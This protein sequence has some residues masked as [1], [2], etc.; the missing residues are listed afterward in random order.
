M[1]LFGPS[2]TMS[3]CWQRPAR[4]GASDCPC[5][6]L[7]VARLP[8]MKPSLPK[9]PGREHIRQGIRATR[10]RA[11]GGTWPSPSR[12]PPSTGPTTSTRRPPSSSAPSSS[13]PA[14]TPSPPPPTLPLSLPLAKPLLSCLPSFQHQDTEVPGCMTVGCKAGASSFIDP[15]PH[16]DFPRSPDQDI[17]LL[18]SIVRNSSV[19]TMRPGL[20]HC[21]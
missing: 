7:A 3:V 16:C 21:P 5:L 9:T 1:K 6:T 8:A 11:G 14:L 10:A 18:L 4:L 17:T 20:L 15:L 2:R 13:Y 12:T 19:L